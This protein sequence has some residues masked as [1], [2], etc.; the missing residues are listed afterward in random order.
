V[1]F[2]ALPY[3]TIYDNDTEGEVWV[4]P[5]H[6]AS[7]APYRKS[8]VYNPDTTN[9]RMVDGSWLVIALPP[10]E[11]VASLKR[12]PHRNQLAVVE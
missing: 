4:N 12:Q 5:N 1:T 3:A 7:V 11:V 10:E 9:L 2:I 6:V 8:G